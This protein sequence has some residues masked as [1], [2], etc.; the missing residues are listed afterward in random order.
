MI[1]G[2]I[3]VECRQV[4]KKLLLLMFFVWHV[5]RFHVSDQSAL[6]RQLPLYC[7]TSLVLNLYLFVSVLRLFSVH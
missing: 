3:I 2:S 1:V 5:W 6:T 4:F 7:A